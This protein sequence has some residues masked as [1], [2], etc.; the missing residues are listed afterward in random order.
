[1]LLL[2]QLV[3]T[4]THSIQLNPK[5]HKNL[6]FPRALKPSFSPESH[7]HR[8]T[9]S[10]TL[11][12]QTLEIL[13]WASV[14]NQLSAFTST[15]MG[16]STSRKAGIPLG[17]SREESQK[18]LDQTT[19]AVAAMEMMRHR[20]LDFSGIKEVS[21]IVNS[22]AS[23][24]LLTVKELCA[25]RRTLSAARGLFEKLEDLAMS[26]VC[27]ERL[28]PLLE[29]LKN[30]DFQVELE[31]KIG[32]CIDCNLSIILDRASDD[33]EM[34]RSERKMNMENLDSLLK[35][36]STRIFQAG[37]IDSPLVTKRRSR[38]C[39]G[40]RASH[41]NLL[42]DG[43]VLDVSS[44]GATYFVEPKEAVELNNMEVRL[45]NAE[46][47]QEIAILSLVTSEI[48]KSKIEIKYLL[49]KILEVDLAFARAGYAR[50]INGV[51][52][53]FSPEDSEVLDFDKSDYAMSVDIDGIQHPLLLESSLKSF[54]YAL[55]SDS[56]NSVHSIEENGKIHSGKLSKGRSSFPVPIDIKI[57]CGTRVVVISGPNTGGKTASIKTLGLASIMSKAGM[58]LPAENH[59]K[60]PWFNLVLAD[61]GDQQSLEQNLSTFSGHISRISN[62]LEVVSKKS[63]VLLDEIG[64]GTDPSEG[65][66]LSSSILQ[67]LKDHVNLA[68]VT[69]HYVDLSRLKEKDNRFENAAMEFSLQTLQPTYRILWGSSGDSNALNIAKTIGFNV[70]IIK[71]ANEWME[72]LIP[73]KQQERKGLLYWSLMEERDRLKA[74]AKKAASL[75]AEII[76]LYH[77]IHDEAEDLDTRK[78]ALMTKETLQI[79]DEV[80]TAKSKM[81]TVLQEFESQLRT[82]SSDQYNLLIRKSE[83][84][85]AS[86][87]EAHCPDDDDDTSDSESDSN[88][89]TPQVGEL[90]S[91]KALRDK[92]ATVVEAPGDDETILVQYGKIKVR[93]KKSDIRAIPS[94]NK[95]SVTGSSPRLKRQVRQSREF[96][97]HSGGSKD[98]EVSYGPVVQTSKNTVDLRGMRV[99]EASYQLE[100]AISARE[101]YS[102]L[103][104]IH[105]M[106]TGAVKERAIEILASH[107]RVAKYEQESPMNYGCTVAYIK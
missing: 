92:L 94:R 105:G 72:S 21:G 39:V 67:Y 34:I 84:A 26:E 101:S 95:K 65:L 14:C 4:L 99:E 71:R 75:N 48:A 107:P 52:P 55:M 2:S 51:C 90:V 53:T 32:F 86:I 25:V 57:G 79:Q 15:S 6:F 60:L 78:T 31:Q 28:L 17:R 19:A 37:G 102:V 58:Y 81:E 18:L 13:E 12:S 73:E 41:R 88:S 61:V 47:A 104:V 74:Q 96:K 24:E 42:S 83:S 16:L 106:G 56:E 76:D 93:V 23:G 30:C 9:L 59:P 85:I 40:I 35:R 63:L 33:L 3:P 98:E 91:L 5:Q 80:K 27:R 46:R 1:M 7:S 103:F 82:A 43:V 20:P 68:V 49:D 29:I 64:G 100:M 70:D 22:A 89:F 66:A 38:M 69:T 77:E 97:S 54:P 45:S 10:Q 62:I 8:L 11:Q 87:L 50:W 36:E 44:S